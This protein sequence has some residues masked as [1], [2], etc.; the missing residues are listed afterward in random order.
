MIP[1][2]MSTQHPDNV[3]IPFFAHESSLGGE[4][5]VLEAFLDQLTMQSCFMR[6]KLLQFLRL[7]CQ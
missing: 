7:F 1:R 6:K 5:E 3:Y 4:D 2:T